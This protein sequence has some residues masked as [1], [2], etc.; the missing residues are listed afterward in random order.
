MVGGG[1]L[2]LGALLAGAVVAPA[3][4]PGPVGPQQAQAQTPRVLRVAPGQS[5]AAAYRQASPGDEIE[6]VS[7]TY[8]AETIGGRDTTGWGT[9]VVIR[10]APGAAPVLNGITVRGRVVLRELRIQGSVAFEP[11][12]D[13]SRLERSTVQGRTSVL[14]VRGVVISGNRMANTDADVLAVGANGPGTPPAQD[15][16]IEYNELGPSYLAPGSSAH[17][18]SLQFWGAVNTVVRGN[19]IR[20][21]DSETVL[22]KGDFGPM[23]N[24]TFDNNVIWTCAPRRAGCNGWYG[25]NADVFPQLGANG[26]VSGLVVTRNTFVGRTIIGNHPGA[27][28]T[29]NVFTAPA[30]PGCPAGWSD[31]LVAPG[32]PGGCAAANTVAAAVLAGDGF[33]LAP[34]SPGG[35]RG[36]DPARL[37]PA[38]LS[39]PRAGAPG[40]SACTGASGYVLVDEGGRLY[41]FGGA[42]TFSSPSPRDGT[43][44]VEATADRAGLWLVDRSGV[45]T[46]VGAAPALSLPPALRPGER[47]VSISGTPSARGYWLFSDLG[48]VFAFGDA[49]SFGDMGGTTLNGPVLDSVGTPSGRGYFMV[50]SDGGV[51][52]FGDARFAGSMGG[53]RLNAPVR[54]LVPTCDQ[55]GYW[56]VAEDGGVFAFA[57]PFR[58]SV[59]GV[60][61][62][63]QR[64]N[65]PVQGMV[66]YGDGYL[67]VATDGGVFTFSNLP[68]SGGLGGNP[69]DR[70]VRSIAVL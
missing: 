35:G 7:G 9:G 3:G 43:V 19:L 62:A 58:G 14:S 10:P 54:S 42:P 70:P 67:M 38:A 18:N 63:G 46:T 40:G 51:F 22:V 68:F 57:A 66:P 61:R 25:L 36:V 20:E 52:A 29:G 16:V 37:G 26:T 48:R 39:G 2:L 6:L 17:T 30:E 45:V 34:G 44:D 55:R 28:V 11:G 65:A 24:T 8:P 53:Q 12:G 21:S 5:I 47:I 41:R 27:R 32:S 60:L 49:G 64:L 4:V 13:G 31:N 69:P 56:L 15:T 23:T 50:A 1:A 33:S 59:P